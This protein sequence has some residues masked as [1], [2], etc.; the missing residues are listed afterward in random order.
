MKNLFEKLVGSD[1]KK[2]DCCDIQIV[3]VNETNDCCEAKEDCCE[4][5]NK[6]DKNNSCCG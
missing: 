4:T 3:E 1:K 2:S 5:D 6:P